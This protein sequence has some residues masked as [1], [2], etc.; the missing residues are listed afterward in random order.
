MLFLPSGT[1]ANLATDHVRLSQRRV[2]AE[3]AAHFYNSEGSELA[4]WPAS[5]RD[6]SG[7]SGG[8]ARNF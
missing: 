1:V 4:F 5:H 2:I 6:R 3:Q 8:S 7:T